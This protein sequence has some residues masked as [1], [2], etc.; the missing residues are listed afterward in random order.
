MMYNMSVIT[1]FTLSGLSG[2]TSYWVTLFTLT[3]L[4]YCAIWL[5][6]VTVVVTIIVDK[7]LHEPMYIFLCNLCINGLYGAAGFYPKFLHDLLSSSHLISVPG[8]FLQGFVL[9]SSVGADVSLLALMA[10]DRYVAICRPLVY[11]SVMTKQRVCIYVFIAWFLPFCL[12]FISTITTATSKLCGSQIPK[13]YCLNVLISNLA[14]S[15]SVAHVIVPAFNYTFYFGHVLFI[16]SSYFCLVKTCQTSKENKEKFMQTCVPHLFSLAV[17]VFS[18][19]FD[20]MYIRFGTKDLPQNVQN[21]I[22]IEFILIPPL[23]NPL[24]YGFR[25]T[26]LRKRVFHVICCKRSVSR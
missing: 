13:I 23:I 15:A 9:H 18:L 21:F 6:N 11:H 3:L 26:Q 5:I 19:L 2:T 7:N 14:C 1:M 22:A 25:L 4:C 24:I 12:L 17:L 20:M 10:Y 16:I 8:C